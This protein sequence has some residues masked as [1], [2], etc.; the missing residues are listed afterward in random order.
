MC[1]V[2]LACMQTATINSPT[3]QPLESPQTNNAMLQ[4]FCHLR[5]PIYTC[6]L[7]DVIVSMTL[8][9]L[10]R[11]NIDHSLLSDI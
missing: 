8:R 4:Q 11:H 1:H 3:V 7:F 10:H 6:C 2:H 5:Y 9:V